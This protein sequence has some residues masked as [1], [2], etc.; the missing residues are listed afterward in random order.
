MNFLSILSLFKL[1][2]LNP[3]EKVFILYK[4]YYVVWSVCPAA[5]LV[6]WYLCCDT[7]TDWA[8]DLRSTSAVI[9]IQVKS[10]K[11]E[12]Y[13]GLLSSWLKLVKDI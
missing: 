5:S 13:R 4:S 2:K 12:D 9:F 7:A 6:Q 1:T 8:A 10:I 3:N 11:H